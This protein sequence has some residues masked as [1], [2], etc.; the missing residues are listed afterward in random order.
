M[1]VGYSGFVIV[2]RSGGTRL[3][4]LA[5]V[6]DLLVAIRDKVYADGWRVGFLGTVEDTSEGRLAGD[7]ARETG[8]PAIALSIF[9]SDC[10]FATA[11]VPSGGVVDFYLDEEV[12]MDLAEGD[13]RIQPLNDQATAGLLAWAG[14]AGLVADPDRLAAALE[15][16]PGPFGS[17]IAHF[18]EALGIAAR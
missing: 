16:S 12:V 17:G 10:A 11:A 18:V 13:D 6:Q 1:I 5:C 3:D 14:T 4:E 2:A 9:D 8:A 15:E 7:L